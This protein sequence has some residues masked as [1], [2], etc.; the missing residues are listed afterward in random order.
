[1]IRPARPEEA[2]ALAALA[3]RAYADY[4]PLIGRRPAPMDDDYAARIAAGQAW[5]LEA[6]EGGLAALLVLEPADGHLW[7]DN[8]A[9]DPARQRGGLGRALMRFV[10]REAL[11]RGLPEVRLLTN[12][13][14]ERNLAFY[15]RLG[16]AELERREEKGFRR[17][18]MVAP[19]ELLAASPA[20]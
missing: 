2:G 12:E 15:A 11:R 10:A 4:V 14:M 7:L 9:V 17:V 13:R 8:V 19:A 20:G 6:E 16:F 3:E 5:V 18:F 1:M